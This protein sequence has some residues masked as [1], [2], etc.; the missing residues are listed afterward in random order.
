M[1]VFE[2]EPKSKIAGLGEE[3]FLYQGEQSKGSSV[4]FRKSNFVVVV[5]GS[6]VVIAEDFSKQFAEMIDGK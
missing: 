1:S 5:G 4:V 3:A 2:I 6:S